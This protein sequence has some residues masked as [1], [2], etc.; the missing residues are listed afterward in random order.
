MSKNHRKSIPFICP[1]QYNR[2]TDYND[3]EVKWPQVLYKLLSPSDEVGDQV[4]EVVK[5]N[6]PSRAQFEK[7][8]TFDK[9]IGPIVVTQMDAHTVRAQCYSASLGIGIG[10]L[11]SMPV[12]PVDAALI[13]QL[14][15]I[16]AVH[17]P[18]Y[19]WR[20]DYIYTKADQQSQEFVPTMCVWHDSVNGA[21]KAFDLIRRA[22]E[23][24]VEKWYDM[25][26]HFVH[27]FLISSVLICL[28]LLICVLKY[29]LGVLW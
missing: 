12:D 2:L 26:S 9:H 28:K 27:F 24:V 20:L 3:D 23:N 6:S 8:I 13:K 29:L 10:L 15:N 17:L 16:E 25:S 7:G 5:H 14:L 18:G 21:A 1:T 22:G 11:W 4:S 19:C